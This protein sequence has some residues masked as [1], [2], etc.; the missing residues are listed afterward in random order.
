[1]KRILMGLLTALLVSACQETGI[2]VGRRLGRSASRGLPRLA[3]K[4]EPPA[5]MSS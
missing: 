2:L 3:R 5:C 4:A 1:M